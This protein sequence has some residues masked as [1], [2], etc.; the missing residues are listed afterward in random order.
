MYY[1]V[2]SFICRCGGVVYR[3]SPSKQ[4]SK[5]DATI[6]I[7]EIEKVQVRL[8]FRWDAFIDVGFTGIGEAGG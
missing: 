7:N 2:F 8:C 4:A 5:A 3:A 6:D 1:V